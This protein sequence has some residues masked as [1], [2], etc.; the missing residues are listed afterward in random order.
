MYRT[1]IALL[2][3]TTRYRSPDFFKFFIVVC[4]T[5]QYQINALGRKPYRQEEFRAYVLENLNEFSRN[6]NYTEEQWASFSEK[7]TF[8]NFDITDENSFQQLN[9]RL[10]AFDV[11]CN[12]RANRLFY[13][14]VAPSFIDKVS[15]NLKKTGLA[16]E[17]EKDR[18]IIEKP[19]GYDKA[20]AIA[21][22]RL[23][24]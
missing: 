13:L 17:I 12:N 1:Q 14:S 2:L 19:F 7:I 6:N 24:N 9:E 8:L 5:E 15:V 3:Y 22:N 10:T 11:D 23:L 16:S 20:S 4:M 18:I 21:L